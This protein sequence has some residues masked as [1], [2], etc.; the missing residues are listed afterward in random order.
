MPQDA[1]YTWPYQ[2]QG[3]VAKKAIDPREEPT[4]ITLL[5]INSIKLTPNDL[6]F[7]S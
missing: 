6:L 2:G 5:K 7:Q 3:P 4:G 1:T